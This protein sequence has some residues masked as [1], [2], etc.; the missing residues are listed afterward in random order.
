MSGD[1][2]VVMTFSL[3]CQYAAKHYPSLIHLYGAPNGLCL[4]IME[5][6]YIKAVKEPWCRSSK[7]NVLG[8]MLRTNQHLDKIATAHMDFKSQK[9]FGEFCLSSA[10]NM[11]GAF[12]FFCDYN[13]TYVWYSLN[14]YI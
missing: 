6:K 2:P 10:I 9:I 4:S 12:D 1:N 8:Q 11:L 13:L 5:W 3:P 14:Y 7:F